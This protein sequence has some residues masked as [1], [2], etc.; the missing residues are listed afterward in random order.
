M[1]DLDLRQ[2]IDRSF[3]DGPGHRP[4][5]QRIG[6]GRRAVVRRR[7]A[8]GVAA[9][10]AVVAIGGAAWAVVP[11]EPATRGAE[12]ASDPSTDS[13]PVRWAADDPPVRYRGGELEV[14]PGAVVHQHIENPY[15]L[16]PPLTSDALD[17]TYRGHR[18]WMVIDG[19]PGSVAIAMTVP[20]E[21]Y[22]DFEDYVADQ[23]RQN[24]YGGPDLVRLTDEG[25]VVA[26]PGA[27]IL[28]RT[29]DPGL[30]RGFAPPGTPTGAA[31]LRT[32]H[33]ESYFVVW[34]VVDGEL[35]VFTAPPRDVV[36][37]TF[38]E[39][40]SYARGRYGSGEGR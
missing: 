14:A 40:L 24:G 17:L 9:L 25:A 4:V 36:G 33:E 6:A 29:D 23:A 16:A 30:G 31:V 37:A 19:Q 12:I 35:A 27:E 3:G 21:N 11:G 32:G 7:V 20:L 13:A 2:E 8:G 10:A 34:R 38:D 28:Q 18:Q 26:G 5:E 15:G 1:V 22:A 39:L